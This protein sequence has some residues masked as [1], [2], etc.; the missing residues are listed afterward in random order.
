MTVAFLFPGQGA[1]TVGMG[2]DLYEA[3]PAAKRVFDLA[4]ETLEM[5]VKRLCFDGP[6]EELSRTDVCQPAIL[7]VSAA[8][9]AVM[10]DLLGPAAPRPGFAAGLS[11]R[12]YTA[13]LAAGALELPDAL[14][15]VARRGSAMQEAAAAADSGMVSVLGLDEQ[16]ARSLCEAAAEGQVLT[17]ANFNCP[18]QIVLS[19]EKAACERAVERAEEFGASRAV[20]LNVAGAFH[21]EL[22]APAA[23]RLRSALQAVEFRPPSGATVVANVDAEPYADARGIAGKLLAQLTSPVRWQQSVERLIAQ[24]ADEFYEIG[25]GRVL[26]GLMRRIDR[27]HRVT[28]LN[29]R[30][31]LEALAT[32]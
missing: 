3:F 13:L 8:V 10:E 11:L 20:P 27:S 7:T 17:C 25:P 14:R 19:G 4:E 24:G 1:Q 26:A 30:E 6:D 23:E 22:M 2:R 16:Q 9:L 21:C 32:A 18:G 12:E 15:L 5:P 29:G 31:S 28:C